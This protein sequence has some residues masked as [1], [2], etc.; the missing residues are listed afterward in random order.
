MMF[1]DVHCKSDSQQKGNRDTNT[2]EDTLNRLDAAKFYAR[3]TWGSES[4]KTSI[5]IAP[6]KPRF[7]KRL[8]ILDDDP[9]EKRLL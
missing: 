8:T 4:S 7:E 9:L 3:N 5:A 1:K 2:V 6:I